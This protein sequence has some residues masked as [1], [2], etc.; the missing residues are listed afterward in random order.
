[1]PDPESSLLLLQPSLEAKQLPAGF[2]IKQS[3]PIKLSVVIVNYRQW[4]YTE[5]HAGMAGNVSKNLETLG[6]G[7]S[8]ICKETGTK[9]RLI[10]LTLLF[11][12]SYRDICS[13]KT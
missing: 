8:Y 3:N 2:S 6:C 12:S 5:Q 9:T 1:M 7:V 10:D 4:K 13:L 11:K